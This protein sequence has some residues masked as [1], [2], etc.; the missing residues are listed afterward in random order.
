M[1]L[2][3]EQRVL[4]SLKTGVKGKKGATCPVSQVAWGSDSEEKA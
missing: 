3:R 4:E 2:R 1:Y